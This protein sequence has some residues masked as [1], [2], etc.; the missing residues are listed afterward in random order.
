MR[1]NWEE[2]TDMCEQATV[3]YKTDATIPQNASPLT[4]LITDHRSPLCSRTHSRTAKGAVS[5]S[6]KPGFH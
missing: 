6:L 2:G 5:I 3:V 4:G 1:G